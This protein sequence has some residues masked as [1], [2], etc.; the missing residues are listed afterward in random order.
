MSL[1]EHTIETLRS[2]YDIYKSEAQKT[3]EKLMKENEQLHRRIDALLDV[4]S[5][6]KFT[7]SRNPSDSDVATTRED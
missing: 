1:P 2:E 7:V 4:K 5:M 3:I 6:P